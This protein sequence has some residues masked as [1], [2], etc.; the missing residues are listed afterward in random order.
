MDFTWVRED[1]YLF[2]L[3]SFDV[4]AGQLPEGHRGHVGVT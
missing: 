3:S 1:L 4:T 2:D